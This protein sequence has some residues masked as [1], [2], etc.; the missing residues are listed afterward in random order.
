LFF[1]CTQA[2][3]SIFLETYSLEDDVVGQ[4]TVELL[5]EAAN[6]G[7][8]RRGATQSRRQCV[9]LT[10]FRRRS[11]DADLRPLWL[12]RHNLVVADVEAGRRWRQ[13]HLVQ[14]HLQVAV[15]HDDESVSAQSQVVASEA[16]SAEE[17][18]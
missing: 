1:A 15:E 13:R 7:A 17:T 16:T 11:S 8:A 4:K 18:D 10:R 12:A 2:N 3:S 9:S 14:S 6:R 5:S